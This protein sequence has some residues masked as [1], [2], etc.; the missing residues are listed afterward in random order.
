MSFFNRHSTVRARILR[1]RQSGGASLVQP[2]TGSEGVVFEGDV[3]I[4]VV[5]DLGSVASW[6][7]ASPNEDHAVQS[8]EALKPTFHTSGGPN[9]QPYL[10]FAADR[11]DAPIGSVAIPFT[12]LIVWKVPAPGA[13][14][15]AFGSTTDV[16]TD[17]Q[18]LWNT[19]S[20]GRWRYSG[21]TFTTVSTNANLLD[22][23][24]LSIFKRTT[25]NLLFTVDGSTIFSGAV[26]NENC[27]GQQI[28]NFDGQPDASGMTF[29]VAAFVKLFAPADAD[30]TEWSTY[31]NAKYLPS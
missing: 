5:S 17:E 18:F 8:T 4:G 10:S 22:A 29:D 14:R 6:T 31:L 26:G 9:D 30:I 21:G 13:N 20:G 2:V 3:L 15:W 16:I 7:D 12:L 23:W 27:N 19:A 28:G 25:G 11:M 1:D 24:N